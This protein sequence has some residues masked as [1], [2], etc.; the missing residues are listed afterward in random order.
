VTWEIHLTGVTSTACCMLPSP[1]T[2]WCGSIDAVLT[3]YLQWSQC[4][5]ELFKVCISWHLRK[6]V[7]CWGYWMI[8]VS[9]PCNMS[10]ST[11]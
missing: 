6:T 8:H 5:C 7:R 2:R 1:L 3:V 10:A 4:Y 9:E 11:T